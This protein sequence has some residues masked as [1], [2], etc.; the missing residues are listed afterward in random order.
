MKK[1]ITI[2]VASLA[3]TAQADSA[4]Q[5]PPAKG[6][7]RM[8]QQ[9]TEH[10]DSNGKVVGTTTDIQ[11]D[12]KDGKGNAWNI[13]LGFEYAVIDAQG[14]RTVV[15]PLVQAAMARAKGKKSR[16]SIPP[17]GY[18][19]STEKGH[20]DKQT[21]DGQTVAGIWYVFEFPAT[22]TEPAHQERWEDWFTF[23]E[24]DGQNK[25]RPHRRIVTSSTKRQTTDYWYMESDRFHPSFFS[26]EV[27]PKP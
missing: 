6:L 3:L 23:V 12:M 14:K 20:F 13:P 4:K 10:L 2:L 15:N 26:A 27:N 7:L 8:M 9:T 11:F 16:T 1:I 5:E 22:E 25:M 19:V 18:L 24:V 17:D 21:Q